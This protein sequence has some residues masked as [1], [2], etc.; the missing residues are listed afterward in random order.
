M[1]HVC[2]LALLP[3]VVTQ[4]GARHVVTLLGNETNVNCPDCIPRDNH[5]WLRMHDIVSPIDGHIIPAE[6]HVGDLLRFVR[7]WD[8]AAPM[9]VHCYAGISRSTAAAFTTVCALNPR[10]DEREIALEI[11][12][13]SPTACPNTRIVAYADKLL[14]REGRMIA[15]VESIGR[16][17]IAEEGVPFSLSLE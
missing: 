12:Q 8:R 4:T 14:G 10:R 3:S 13:A 11:R 9:V 5:L 7:N 17:V 15:A 1:I 6:D 2:S 16:G